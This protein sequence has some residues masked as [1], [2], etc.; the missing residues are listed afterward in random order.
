MDLNILLDDDQFNQAV[1]EWNC[2][3]QPYPSLKTII[4]L[5]EAQAAKTPDN[6][7]V[8]YEDI[9]LTYRELNE[10]ANLLALCLIKTYN[11]QADD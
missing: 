8:A 10:K 3:E 2:T 11:I 5:F 9:K 7:A 1:Y 4:E 6:I